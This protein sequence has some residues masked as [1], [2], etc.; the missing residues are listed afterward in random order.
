MQAIT[1]D[2]QPRETGKKA[3]KAVR[4][5]GL[6]PCVLYGSHTEPVHF[7]VEALQLRPLVYTTETYRVELAV[8]G[9]QHDAIV[10]EV[11]F[12]PVTDE[13]VHA[14]F[15][16]LT[17]G[18]ALTMTIPVRLEGTPVGVKGGGV[19]SQP[20]QELE[21]RALPKDIPG[22]VS[23]DVAGL[24]VGDSIHVREIGFGDAIEIMTDVDRT[25]AVVSAPR[26]LVEDT[27]DEAVTDLLGGEA[28]EGEAPE[29]EGEAGAPDADA[30]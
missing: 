18:E 10:K 9:D 20:L 26:A 21:I 27:E 5:A 16:A 12:H 2:P 22:H 7:A 17:A 8:G 23:I 30:E 11:V 3:T 15:L 25:V 19:L 1:L 13:P 6:V 29:G 14:D 28:I 24:A 4:R